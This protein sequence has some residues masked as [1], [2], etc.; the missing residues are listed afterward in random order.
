M[1]SSSLFVLEQ[2]TLLSNN[3]RAAFKAE[4][5]PITGNQIISGIKLEISLLNT[6][7][8]EVI[9]ARR[10]SNDTIIFIPVDVEHPIKIWYVKIDTSGIQ[11]KFAEFSQVK[12]STYSLTLFDSKGEPREYDGTSVQ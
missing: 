4:K 2:E 11:K 9:R 8:G 1:T 7:I 3:I 10:I 5:L 12:N 6:S